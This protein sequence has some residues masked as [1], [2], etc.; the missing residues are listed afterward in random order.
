MESELKEMRQLIMDQ[1]KQMSDI[2]YQI[3]QL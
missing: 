1:H 2:Q 3:S